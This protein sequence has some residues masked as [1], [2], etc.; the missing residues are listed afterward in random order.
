MIVET[1]VT[2]NYLF[3]LIKIHQLQ[4]LL[5]QKL[6]KLQWQEMLLEKLGRMLEEKVL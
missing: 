6:F 5:Y 3:G 4:K 1:L 2:K